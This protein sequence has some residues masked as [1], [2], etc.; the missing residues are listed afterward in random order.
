MGRLVHSH[1][2][3]LVRLAGRDILNARGV[4]AHHRVRQRDERP[5]TCACIRASLAK[6]R[7]VVHRFK[8]CRWLRIRGLVFE[9]ALDFFEIS[10]EFFLG[11]FEVLFLLLHVGLFPMD[12]FLQASHRVKELLAQVN[13]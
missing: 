10:L 3:C 6:T 1:A 12:H 7:L 8:A 13:H 4:A 11:R 5:C 9:L 2:L